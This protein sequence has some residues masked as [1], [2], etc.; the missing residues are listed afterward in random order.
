MVVKREHVN[1]FSQRFV[2]CFFLTLF[3]NPF[4][5]IIIKTGRKSSD[6]RHNKHVIDSLEILEINWLGAAWRLLIEPFRK[7]NFYPECRCKVMKKNQRLGGTCMQCLCPT[8]YC[9]S[10]GL[11]M[12]VQHPATWIWDK[13]FMQNKLFGRNFSQSLA[14]LFDTYCLTN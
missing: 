6:A 9:G 5:Q 13:S 4:K 1:T 7:E 11:D 3:L 8:N 10:L 2:W 12:Q 14:F